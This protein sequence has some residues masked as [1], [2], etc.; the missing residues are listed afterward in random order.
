MEITHL[1]SEVFRKSK[2]FCLMSEFWY[3]KWL[4][5]IHQVGSIYVVIYLLTPFCIPHIVSIHHYLD[6][7]KIIV[8][9]NLIHFSDLWYAIWKLGDGYMGW[10][11]GCFRKWSYLWLW[12]TFSPFSIY[13]TVSHQ[14]SFYF[15]QNP[16]WSS[17]LHSQDELHLGR[18]VNSITKCVSCSSC[19]CQSDRMLD[20]NLQ[21]DKVH[22]INKHIF[23][24]IFV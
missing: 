3:D 8:E 10:G 2:H 17:L 21:I 24:F 5:I 16:H 23:I 15:H 12:R 14:C 7:R 13:S 9:V 6:R 19:C 18:T 4:P 20:I 1:Q 22:S 11:W